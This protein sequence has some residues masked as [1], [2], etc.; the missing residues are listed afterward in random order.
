MYVAMSLI[1]PKKCLTLA[2]IELESPRLPVRSANHS[3]TRPFNSQK[4]NFTNKKQKG[5]V[6]LSTPVKCIIVNQS[7]RNKS[8][9]NSISRPTSTRVSI[10]KNI[11]TLIISYNDCQIS[12]ARYICRKCEEDWTGQRAF[13]NNLRGNEINNSYS[14][15]RD[16]S[17]AKVNNSSK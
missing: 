14:K 10:M 5:H 15:R 3:A 17:N 6:L 2:G 8:I 16:R 11:R 9:D 7:I 12:T 1:P 13:S 4:N